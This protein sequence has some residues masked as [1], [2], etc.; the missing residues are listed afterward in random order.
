M[1]RRQSMA[2]GEIT[3]AALIDAAAELFAEQGIDGV[4]I[5]SVNSRA[6]L[7][8][9]AVHYHFGSK[10][11]LLDAVL[12]R[13]GKPVAGEIT[14]AADRLLARRR[15]PTTR[16]LVETLGV[17]YLHLLEGDPVRGIWW[18]KIVS[19][20]SLANDDRLL[21]RFAETSAK[22]DA[23]VVRRFSNAPREVGQRA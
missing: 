13:D 2:E 9:A 14:T 21:T 8:P 19:Q 18:L 5:R 3:R 16:H 12:L 6:G 17:P 15:A 23:L 10:D 1:G 20:L 7:A 11:R 4:S 22:M